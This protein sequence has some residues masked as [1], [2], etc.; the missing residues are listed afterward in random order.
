MDL[1]EL[2]QSALNKHRDGDVAGA[3]KIYG[4]ILG[5]EPGHSAANLNLASIALDQGQLEEAKGMLLPVMAQ[6]EDNGVAHLLYSRACF[7][8][9]KH[10]EGYAHIN[11]AFELMP[12]EE[13][14]ATEFVA[15]MRRKYFTFEDTEYH[16]LFEKAQSNELAPEKLQRLAHLTFLRIMRPE[17]IKL[18]I[19]PGLPADTPDALSRWVEELPDEAQTELAVLARNFMQ[20]VELMRGNERYMAGSGTL[21]LRQTDDDPAPESR[22]FEVLEDADSMTGATLEI[23][24]H[25]EVVFV[26]FSE[27][28]SID[29]NQP[30]AVTGV[31]ITLRDGET[32]SGLMPLFYLFTEFASDEKIRQGRSTLIRPVSGDIAAGVGLRILRVDGEPA[33]V[34]K[35]EKI[36]FDV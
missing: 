33:P 19:E 16:A 35:I 12:D 26:P 32:I 13:G 2:L 5:E 36:E 23:V 9:G 4:E 3:A 30:D 8:L 24:R 14:I 21:H 18:I 25:G 22:K 28:A 7:Q 27:I 34:V 20:A 17:L 31:F 29:F 11:A 1:D 6:D 15:A 10:E